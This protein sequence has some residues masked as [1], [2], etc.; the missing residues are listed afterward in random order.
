VTFTIQWPELAGEPVR[1]PEAEEIHLWRTDLDEASGQDGLLFRALSPLE[2]ERAR[3]FIFEQPRRRYIAGRAWLRSVLGAYLKL[4]PTAVPLTTGAHGKPGLAPAADGTDLRF[5]LSHSG[6]FAL[7]AVTAGREIGVDV[8]AVLADETWPAI[9][10]RCFT[11]EEWALVQSLPSDGRATAGAEIWTRKEAAGKALGL[12][13]SSPVWSRS[14]GPAA[15]G[16]V[17]CGNGLCVW[18]LPTLDRLAAAVAVQS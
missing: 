8:Q 11:P 2:Q 5:N 1:L 6:H 13:L 10:G 14:V 15:W 16:K 18:S 3:R 7:L 4:A 17:H 12:G 9:A